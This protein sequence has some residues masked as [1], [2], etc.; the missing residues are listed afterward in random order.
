AVTLNGSTGKLFVNGLPVATNASMSINPG[1]VGTKFNFLGK[2]RF[3][4][5]PLFSGRFDDFRF[6]SSALT[7]AHVAAIYNTPPPQF[8]ATTLYKP[9]AAVGQPYNATLAG[10]ATGT[11]ALTF[12]KMDG[13]AWLAVAANGALTGTPAATDGGLNTFLVRV[14][15]ANGSL[16][17]AT[18]IILVPTV[19]ATIAVASGEDDAEQSA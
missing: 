9:A 5:D 3:P 13:P 19:T 12:S 15:D 1:D 6:V 8:R 16:N 18:L 17:T 10:D 2:S 14:T 11:G 4:A 7:D